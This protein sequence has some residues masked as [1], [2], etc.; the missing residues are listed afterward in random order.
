[1]RIAAL[2][3]AGLLVSCQTP[4]FEAVSGAVKEVAY[5]EAHQTRCEKFHDARIKAAAQV[6]IITTP[7][8]KRLSEINDIGHIICS[9][10]LDDLIVEISL[11]TD[12]EE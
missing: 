6:E 9:N 10:L 8:L 4:E 7:D 1:M 5:Q 2:A 11:M 12:S 3:L